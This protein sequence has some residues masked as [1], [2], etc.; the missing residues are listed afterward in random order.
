MQCQIWMLRGGA[1]DGCRRRDQKWMLEP[2]LNALREQG[3]NNTAKR[4]RFARN[5]LV[6]T[7]V[8]SGRDAFRA[9][10]AET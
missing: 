6:R 10:A 9:K 8:F 3:L 5:G 7:A 1:K 4:R 2:E